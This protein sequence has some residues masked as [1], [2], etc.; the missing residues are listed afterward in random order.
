V[1]RTESKNNNRPYTVKPSRIENPF[2]AGVLFTSVNPFFFVWW[3]SVGVKPISDS[4]TLLG[5]P[6]GIAFLF[7]MHIW[8]DYIIWYAEHLYNMK[9]MIRASNRIVLLGLIYGC[10][11]LLFN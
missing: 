10:T 1:V 6:L 7:L 8:M 3:I 11:N 5:Y 2:L 4:I 9:I